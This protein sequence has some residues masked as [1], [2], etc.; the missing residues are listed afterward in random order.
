MSTVST[1]SFESG[2]KFIPKPEKP[3]QAE[4]EKNLKAAQ[5][6]HDNV[7]QK[8]VSFPELRSSSLQG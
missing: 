4:F 8:L 2:K 6:E 5:Q 3:D 1:P 7:R